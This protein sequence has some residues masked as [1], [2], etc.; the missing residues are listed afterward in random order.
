MI[1]RIRVKGFKNLRDTEV[2]FGPFTCIAGP[3]GIGK[4]NL[5]DAIR[6]LSCLANK[7]NTLVEAAFQIRDEKNR[8]KSAA[9]IRNLFFHDGNEYSDTIEFSV[10]MIVPV[11]GTDHLGQIATAT[12]TM[13]QYNLI[14]GFRNGSVISQ[15]P[16][17]IIKEELYPLNKT[18]L[19]I[20]LKKLDVSNEWIQ[21]A[22][23]GKRQNAK[24][25]ISTD[26]KEGTIIIR[27]DQVQGNKKTLKL[28]SMPRTVISTANAVENPTML[29]AK[30]E[31]ENWR[32]LQLEPSALRSP[33]DLIFT[34]IPHISSNGEHL[35]ATIFRMLNDP[36]SNI[37]ITAQ[38]AN[39]LSE[40]LDDVYRISI[41]KDEKRDI[42]TLIIQNKNGTSF[43]AKSLSDGTLRFIAL[44]VIELD[45]LMQG[46]L[47]ME[48]PENGI[49]P[50]RIP[51]IINLL[52]NIAFDFKHAINKDNPLRQVI[53]N[54]HSPLVV[55]EVPDDS[56]LFADFE[57][58]KGTKSV[59]FR[60]LKDTWRTRLTGYESPIVKGKILGYLNPYNTNKDNPSKKT[61]RVID[62]PEFKQLTQLA[63]KQSYYP[64]K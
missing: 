58:R 6:F 37:D 40:L 56:L 48:E 8:K 30:K 15:S 21:S 27:G 35:P 33:D 41:D 45:P 22:L 12:T 14:I 38:L 23:L 64:H 63:K 52:E 17:F 55:S 39:K 32:I 28:D 16:L 3:N 9:D 44:A 29:L 59:I 57:I 7:D 36:D 26:E 11:S 18:D 62:R 1:F 49:H 53:V 51:V 34:E 2:Y 54:T 50:E 10:D 25:F 42:L 47:C 13:L 5:F 61:K 4:S 60:P 43:P 46:L 20:T 24:P 31:F 19:K